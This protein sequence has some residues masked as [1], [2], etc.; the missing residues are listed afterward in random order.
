MRLKPDVQ[1]RMMDMTLF[2]KCWLKSIRLDSRRHRY[3]NGTNSDIIDN[4]IGTHAASCGIKW[5]FFMKHFKKDR[6]SICAS[7]RGFTVLGYDT[8]L[9]AYT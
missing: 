5:I 8:S 7:G 1:R 9:D 3:Y 2:M 6:V 4:V